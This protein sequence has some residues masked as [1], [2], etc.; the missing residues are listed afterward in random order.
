MGPQNVL[1][2]KYLKRLKMNHTMY[3][4]QKYCAGADKAC[5]SK[6]FLLKCPLL[7][8]NVIRHPYV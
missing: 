1:R 2:A 8:F 4:N 3:T 7:N 6:G 5:E